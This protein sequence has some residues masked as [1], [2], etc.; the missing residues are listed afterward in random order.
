MTATWGGCH[1]DQ[2][3]S[4]WDAAAGDLTYCPVRGTCVG[5]LGPRGC[6]GVL[7]VSPSAPSFQNGVGDTT[8]LSATQ[9]P[10]ALPTGLLPLLQGG[11]DLLVNLAVAAR[12][13]VACQG[14]E[15]V[16]RPVLVL[17]VVL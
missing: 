15:S 11:D 17:E 13:G 8:A 16:G 14:G 7:T 6:R 2:E 9:T 4:H 10:L 5:R 3:V 1:A 12:S